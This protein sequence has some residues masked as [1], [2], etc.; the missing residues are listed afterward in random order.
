MSSI[1]LPHLTFPV[2]EPTSTS[3]SNSP[4]PARQLHAM[5]ITEVP[6]A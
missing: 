5:S 3:K 4:E 2:M 6:H 1:L